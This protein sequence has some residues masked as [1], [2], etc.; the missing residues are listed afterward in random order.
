MRSD[1]LSAIRQWDLPEAEAIAQETR[2]AAEARRLEAREGAQRFAS[3][4]G[5]HGT[6]AV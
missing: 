5:R 3:G 2:L 6:G 4:A 1:R